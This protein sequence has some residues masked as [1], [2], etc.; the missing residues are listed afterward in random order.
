MTGSSVC[1]SCV[2]CVFSCYF[3]PVSLQSTIHQ[4]SW[5][6]LVITPT[7]TV[8]IHFSCL[9]AGVDGIYFALKDRQQAPPHLFFA[10]PRAKSYVTMKDDFKRC[11]ASIKVIPCRSSYLWIFEVSTMSPWAVEK[12]NGLDTQASLPNYE[13]YLEFLYFFCKWKHSLNFT[14]NGTLKLLNGVFTLTKD[15]II[16]LSFLLLI[17][18]CGALGRERLRHC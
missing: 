8:D 11:D 12:W 14:W 16:C 10:P 3:R 17:G 5:N 1:F 15:L 13:A 7:T 4:H 9:Y 6:S 18:I 2:L